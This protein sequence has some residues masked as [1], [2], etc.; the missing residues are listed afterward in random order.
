MVPDCALWTLTEDTWTWGKGPGGLEW[1]L[2]GWGEACGLVSAA[3]LPCVLSVPIPFCGDYIGLQGNPKLQKLKGGEEGPVLM[4]EAVKKVNRGNGKTS[5]RIL[6]LTKGHVILTDTKKSQAKIVIGLDNVTGVS[7]TSFK[8]GLF[9]L[10]LSEVSELGGAGLGLEKVVCIPELG[11]AG[12]DG[13][14]TF[15]SG[16]LMSL[17]CCWREKMNPF[18]AIF[19]SS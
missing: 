14:Q 17:R 19:P 12:G 3:H 7:V 2:W 10:H 4:A 18:P 8:D 5:S 11:K 6:L 1:E 13:D 16:P 15:C 9:S